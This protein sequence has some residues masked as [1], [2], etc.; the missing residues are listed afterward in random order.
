MKI[1][2]N[3]VINNYPDLRFRTKENPAPSA[4]PRDGHSFDAIIIQSDPR[5]IE[6][7]NFAKSVSG[8]L[9]SEI[10]SSASPEKIQDLQ[11]QIADHTYQ[12]DA[13]AIASRML[14]V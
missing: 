7:H 3:N 1:T 12:I 4:V 9:S 2:N 14:L 6:E 8:Q 5:K 10:R 13:Y 11:R